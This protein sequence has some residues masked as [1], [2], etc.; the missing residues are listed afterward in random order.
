MTL[1][2]LVMVLLRYVGYS[3]GLLYCSIIFCFIWGV[4]QKLLENVKHA[5]PNDNCLEALDGLVPKAV[6]RSALYKLTTLELNFGLR[7][8]AI[9]WK[10]SSSLSRCDVGDLTLYESFTSLLTSSF[11]RTGNLSRPIGIL[12]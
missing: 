7:F 9:D 12:F 5:G 10:G 6:D 3:L 4:E 8:S 1:F 2:L 11:G